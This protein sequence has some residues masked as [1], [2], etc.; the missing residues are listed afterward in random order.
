MPQAHKGRLALLLLL[1]GPCGPRSLIP[2]MQGPQLGRALG[3]QPPRVQGQEHLW[4]PAWLLLVPAWH[5][6]GSP[7]RSPVA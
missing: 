4:S 3:E 7:G 6:R 2:T 1:A 5:W